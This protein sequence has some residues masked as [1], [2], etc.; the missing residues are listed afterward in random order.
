MLS[1]A[2]N[3]EAQLLNRL[4]LT[5]EADSGCAR[6]IRGGEV[7]A[8]GE[9]L[10]KGYARKLAMPNID[11]AV[12]GLGLSAVADFGVLDLLCLW[13]S[14]SQIIEARK[15]NALVVAREHGHVRAEFIVRAHRERA[16][17]MVVAH[18]RKTAVG[19]AG[20]VVVE[21]QGV[22]VEI[23]G[24]RVLDRA[25]DPLVLEPVAGIDQPGSD[26]P[27]VRGKQRRVPAAEVVDEAEEGT[28]DE[29]VAGDFSTVIQGQIDE[30]RVRRGGDQ[31]VV[32]EVPGV[33]G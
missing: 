1:V 25:I 12:N 21:R 20:A 6:A 2:G 28:T 5:F 29:S 33:V 23:R 13:L 30:L 9:E 11:D 32:A 18:R 8:I 26:L 16:Q 14:V 15:M 7:S 3:I 22:A 24:R 27:G 17:R 10:L 4:P 31:H 19:D